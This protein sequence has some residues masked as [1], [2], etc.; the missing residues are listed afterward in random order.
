M[1]R[2]VPKV[3]VQP[4]GQSYEVGVKSWIARANA[5]LGGVLNETPPEDVSIVAVPVDVRHGEPAPRERGQPLSL[6]W[7]TSMYLCTKGRGF[8]V[9]WTFTVTVNEL[10]AGLVSVLLN[11]AEPVSDTFPRTGPARTLSD[12]TWV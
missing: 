10:L 7:L 3:G 12:I 11:V 9:Y 5:L 6:Q 1:R 2:T 4:A 8:R